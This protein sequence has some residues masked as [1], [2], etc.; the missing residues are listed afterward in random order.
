MKDIEGGYR[1]GRLGVGAQN[2]L[3][4]H[5]SFAR[6]MTSKL[7]DKSIVFS[8]QIEMTSEKKKKKV[9]TQIETV[10]L[11][12]ARNI[13]LGTLAQTTLNCPKF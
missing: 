11:S 13:L 9:F 4:G 1:H 12:S 7:P 2:D 3:G 5:Q 6:K 10:F 8:V